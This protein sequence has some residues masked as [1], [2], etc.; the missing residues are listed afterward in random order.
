MR[1]LR[2]PVSVLAAS[3][4]LEC[5]FCVFICSF[6]SGR[7]LPIWSAWLLVGE[8]RGQTMYCQQTSNASREPQSTN[9]GLCLS[10]FAVRDSFEADT[11]TGDENE[12][13]QNGC[14]QLAGVSRR[15]SLLLTSTNDIQLLASIS[16]SVVLAL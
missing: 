12:M 9:T 5:Q 16:L 7:A 2:A 4:S 10:T 14:R 13:D 6:F 11:R 8:S 3:P 1:A 15:S